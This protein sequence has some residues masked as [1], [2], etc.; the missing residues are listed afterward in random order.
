MKQLALKAYADKHGVSCD[1]RVDER[2]VDDRSIDNRSIDYRTNDRSIDYRKWKW[3][4][5]QVEWI[6]G[7]EDTIFVFVQKLSLIHI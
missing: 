2:T 3:K 7:D 4:W 1:T 5:A 6:V